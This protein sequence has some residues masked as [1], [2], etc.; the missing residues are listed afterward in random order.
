MGQSCDTYVIVLGWSWCVM[1]LIMSMVWRGSGRWFGV[2]MCFRLF[3]SP[4]FVPHWPLSGPVSMSDVWQMIWKICQFWVG[5]MAEMSHFHGKNRLRH[6]KKNLAKFYESVIDMYGTER[7]HKWHIC[8]IM[9]QNWCYSVIIA[10]NRS[11]RYSP[12]GLALIIIEF[13]LNS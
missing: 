10:L 7:L 9:W 8:Q 2:S 6:W 1:V 13:I 11:K 5:K 12:L 3:V 4:F